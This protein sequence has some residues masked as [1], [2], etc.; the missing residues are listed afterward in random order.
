M[1]REERKEFRREAF[2]EKYGSSRT[3]YSREEWLKSRPSEQSSECIAEEERLL[4]SIKQY[5]KCSKM[6]FTATCI[7]AALIAAQLIKLDKG[8]WIIMII[9]AVVLSVAETAFISKCIDLEI[10]EKDF[11]NKM[12]KKYEEAETDEQRE[13]YKSYIDL[14]HS[15]ELIAAL[16]IIASLVCLVSISIV[17]LAIITK[18][19]LI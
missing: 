13:L 19:H 10:S 2:A 14:K 17:V 11:R 5:E 9:V 16:A 15:P 1:N 6:L 4:K 7:Y 12:K 3:L 18:L 8:G